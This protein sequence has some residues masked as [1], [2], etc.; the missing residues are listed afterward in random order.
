[1]HDADVRDLESF[2]RLRAEPA[3]LAERHRRVR[4]VDEI[5]RLLAP[6]RELADVAVERNGRTATRRHDA[7]RDCADVDRVGRQFKKIFRRL[8]VRLV[9]FDARA[10]FSCRCAAADGRK[11]RDFVARADTRLASCVFL[12]DRDEQGASEASERGVRV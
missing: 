10:F 6:A 5:E 11:D 9:R 7:A 4:F 3:H 12:V 8:R 2:V 1:M